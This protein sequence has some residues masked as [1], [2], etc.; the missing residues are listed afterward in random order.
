MSEE[1]DSWLQ[2]ALGV[3]V[4][5]ALQAVKDEASTAISQ[6]VDTVADVVKDARGAIDGAIDSA[7]DA[8]TDALKKA[9]RAVGSSDTPGAA[10]ASGGEGGTGSFPLAGS[11]GRGGKNAPNDVRAVQS[12]L[13]LAADG[14]CGHQTIAAIEAFQ[15][16]KMGV[17]KPDGCIDPGGDTERA[18]AGRGF[19]AA[20]TAQT[21]DDSSSLV[22][23]QQQGPAG[24]SVASSASDPDLSAKIANEL[25]AQI[26]NK[27][28]NPGGPIADLND[29]ESFTKTDPDP[30]PEFTG[31][32]SNAD[33]AALANDIKQEEF[34]IGQMEIQRNNICKGAR[35]D[36]RAAGETTKSNLRNALL[37]GAAIGG[38]GGVATTVISHLGT[39]MGGGSLVLLG[40]LCSGIVSEQESWRQYLQTLQTIVDK[41]HAD[42]TVSNT[43]IAVERK[44]LDAMKKA[45][46]QSDDDEVVIPP[47][48]RP[49]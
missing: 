2:N 20:S 30:V 35:A 15:R 33:P 32:I 26:D 49:G 22:S 38:G 25:A 45:A 47:F 1:G 46:S 19:A 37:G 10:S 13:G 6:G 14:D 48:K 39:A 24:D 8:A 34:A 40:A 29:L 23:A 27:V 11:V 21:V 3:D 43:A 41:A 12:A 28:A 16:G 44:K 18:I 42:L 5:Q 36:A 4:S 7:T 17:A 9:A 31:T